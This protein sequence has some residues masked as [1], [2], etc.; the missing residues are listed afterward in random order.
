MYLDNYKSHL[1]ILCKQ[2]RVKALYVFGSVLTD[3]FS[4]NS[5]IDMVVDIDSSNPL[6]YADNYFNLKF[7]LQDLF[8][9]PVDL[10]ENK[11]IRNKYMR[12][13]ID[14]SKHLVYAKGEAF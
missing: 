12:E 11:A 9:R 4:D 2:N 1:V 7:A 3:R 6:E 10:L 5:D 8:K 13:Q 14:K